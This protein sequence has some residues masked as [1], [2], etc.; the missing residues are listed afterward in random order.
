MAIRDSGI[1]P[2]STF[3]VLFFS[4]SVLSDS[5]ISWNFETAENP[6]ESQEL[7]SKSQKADVKP[8]PAKS[9]NVDD[10]T[11]EEFSFDVGGGF[12]DT[13]VSSRIEAIE[14]PKAEEQKP[15]ELLRMDG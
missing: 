6:L 1:A 3:F 5:G 12:A 10:L 9:L 11:N 15:G 14:L 2:L 4:S 7:A 13:L 8:I